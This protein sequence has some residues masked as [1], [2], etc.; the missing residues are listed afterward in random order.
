MDYVI[1]GTLIRK[2]R[3]DLGWRIADLADKVGVSDDFI[4][5]IERATDIPSLQTIVAIAN[6]L[7]VGVDYL[8]GPNVS[9]I[10]GAL[11]NEINQ[12]LGEMPPKQK[13]LFLQFLRYNQSFFKDVC[14]D[15]QESDS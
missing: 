15:A 14:L 13:K 7:Q 2:R 5:K 9:V 12:L 1:L 10:D 11:C 6:A 8:L 3:Q 4:G